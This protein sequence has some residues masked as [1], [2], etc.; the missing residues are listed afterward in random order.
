MPHGGKTGAFNHDLLLQPARP[1]LRPHQASQGHGH[2]H[3]CH[4]GADSR[5]DIE[6]FG[7]PKA[8][9]LKGFLELPNGIPSHDTFGRVFAHLDAQQFRDCFLQWVQALSAVTG[10][11]VI[12]IDGKTLRRS[13]EKSLSAL[14]SFIG[15]IMK[16]STGKVKPRY[17]TM[18]VGKQKA[19]PW[20]GRDQGI[21]NTINGP[22][23]AWPWRG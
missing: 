3:H 8:G 5:V 15:G 14:T 17:H 13:H 9:W 20:G 4:C 2:H 6:L 10:G 7:K 23:Y 22:F 12:A 11:Q 18:A 16:L 1:S 21:Q 19:G